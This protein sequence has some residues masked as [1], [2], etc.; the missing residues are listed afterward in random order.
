MNIVQYLD[1]KN[2]QYKVS[3]D[4]AILICPECA[5]EKLYIKGRLYILLAPIKKALDKH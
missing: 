4:E 3:G 1:S 2:I 5:R